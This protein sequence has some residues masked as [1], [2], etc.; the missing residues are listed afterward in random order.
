MRWKPPTHSA[1]TKNT[2]Q[3][4]AGVQPIL[5]AFHPKQQA[6]LLTYE[7]YRSDT[8]FPFPVA[9]LCQ[10]YLRSAYSDEF[11]QDFHL[12][13][14]SSIYDTCCSIIVEFQSCKNIFFT[15]SLPN[16][17]FYHSVIRISTAFF[18]CLRLP[19]YKIRLY[20]LATRIQVRIFS[21]SLA[22]AVSPTLSA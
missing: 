10:T 22:E 5:V 9:G 3:G 2:L 15:T 14:F 7:D 12:L 18:T 21:A 17:R 11:V 19:D 16:F 8:A 4:I 1:C 6:G 13:P 20:Y